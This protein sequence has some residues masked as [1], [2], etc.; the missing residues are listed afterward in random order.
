MATAS[1]LHAQEPNGAF[2]HEIMSAS[3]LSDN[4]QRTRHGRSKHGGSMARSGRSRGASLV[5]MDERELAISKA[6]VWIFKHGEALEEL[7]LDQQGFADCAELLSWQHFETLQVTLPEIQEV[8]THDPRQRFVIKVKQGAAATSHEASDWAIGTAQSTHAAKELA[9]M[10][11]ITLEA[12]DIPETVVYS[13]TYAAYPLILASGGLKNTSGSRQLRFS[14][15]VP[16]DAEVLIYVDVFRALQDAPEMT[17]YQ[18]ETQDTVVSEGNATSANSNVLDKRFWKRVV[19]RKFEVGTLF[20]D[21]EEIKEV[22]T[23]L[24]GKKRAM[25]HN[26]SRRADRG[27]VSVKSGEV[28]EL[29]SEDDEALP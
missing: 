6:L 17:W 7:E 4:K 22:P 10:K 14:T 23:N 21:G 27:S 15:E 25:N 11:P 5:N 19:G 3:P 29:S 13:T 26:K 8:A 9:A 20:E 18:S 16:D 28:K 2:H 12:E 1:V 24:R